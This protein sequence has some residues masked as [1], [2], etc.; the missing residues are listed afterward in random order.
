MNVYHRNFSFIS[1][2]SNVLYSNS[3]LYWPRHIQ[4]FSTHNIFSQ[5]SEKYVALTEQASESLQTEF[6]WFRHSNLSGNNI[7]EKYAVGVAY[8]D[9]THISLDNCH[10]PVV[11]SS[12]AW[13]YQIYHQCWSLNSC[14]VNINK[15]RQI[16][17]IDFMPELAWEKCKQSSFWQSLF[18]FL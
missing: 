3:L 17:L 7:L 2:K 11:K 13:I 5:Y 18:V 14:W 1:R 6:A 8:W 16:V 9:K 4:L 10:P 15:D 12:F